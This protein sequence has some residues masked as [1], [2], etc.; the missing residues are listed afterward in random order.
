[1]NSTN[2]RADF[3]RH[4]AARFLGLCFVP[5]ALAA[6]TGG[7]NGGDGASTVGTTSEAVTG[8][9]CGFSVSTNIK[10]VNKKGFRAI[11]KVTRTDGGRLNTTGLSVLVNAGAATLVKVGH[12][13]FQQVENGY[14]LSAVSGDETDD[15]CDGDD[16]TPNDPD[17]LAGRAYRFHLKFEGTYTNLTTTM[18][19]SGG[20]TCDQAAPSV[21]LTTSGELFTSNGTLTLSATASDNVAVSKVVFARDGVE[22]GTVKTAPYTA[23]VPVT[24]AINGRHTFTATA[25][26]LAGNQAAETKRALVAIGNKFFGTAAI[27]AGDYAGLLAHFNQV[28]PGNA[29]KWGSVE[30]TRDVM[31]FTD[32]DTA[33]QFAK[34]NHLPFKLHTLVWG[35]QQPAWIAGL[36]A[37]QQLAELDQWMSALAERYPDADLVDVVNEP[38]HAPPPY[39]AALGGAG[40]TGWDWVVKAFEMARD[41]FP[42]SELLLNDYSILT[43]AQ[44]TQDYLKIVKILNDRGLI[45]GIGEQGHFYERAPEL[46]VLSA[47]LSS[48]VATGLPIYVSE[49]DLNFSDDAQQANRMRDLFSIFWSTPSVLGITHWGYRQQNVWQ[50]NSYL[51]RTD[52]SVRPALTWI[53]CYRAGGTDCPVPPYVPQP[54]TGDVTGITLEAEEYDSAHALLPAGSV[55]AYASDGSWFGYDKVV[56]DGN[57]DTLGVSYAQGGSSPVSLTLHL[58]S[59]DSTPIATVP[60]TP[61]G[62]WSTLQT[63]SIPWAPIAGQHAVFAKF[64]GGGANID[65]LTF[66]A[67]SGTGKNLISDSDLEQGTTAGFFSWG[68]GNIANST[69]RAASGTHS[70]AMTGRSAGA[71]LARS[72]T[73]LVTAGKTYKVSLRASIGGVASAPAY[74]T[75]GIQCGTEATTYGRLGGWDNTKTITDGSWVEFA[76]DLVVPDCALS[77]VQFWLEGPDAGVDMYLD[78]ISVRQV[79]SANIVA[80]GTFESG[81]SGWYTFN[82]G[83]VSQASD[84]AHGGSKSLVVTNRTSNAPAT[85]D[86]TS[87]V[88]AGQSYPFSLWVSLHN[89]DSS[90]GN[91]NVTQAMTCKAA[92][93]TLSTAYNWIA[94]PV[95]VSGTG[96]WT[97]FSGTITVPNCTLTQAQFWVE[98]AVGSDLYVDDVQVIDNAAGGSTNLIGDG[99]FEAG[100]GA[101]GGWGAASIAVTSTSAHGGTQ[102]L[103]GSGMS[104]GALARDIQALVAPGKRYQATAWVSVGNLAASGSVNFQTIQNCNADT[105]DSYPWLA[106]ATVNNSTWV[107]VTGT[108][109]LTACTSINK[110]LLFVGAAAGDLYVDDV[111]LTPLP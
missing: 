96:A 2:Q 64:N 72:L 49:L 26:D 90:S 65:K 74:V 77:N 61:T 24:S 104:N 63:V 6:C 59:V 87:V 103:L 95:A 17:V 29:G 62:G 21:S 110:L 38:L 39:A 68:S 13:T 79:T 105:S 106:G 36:P 28:T 111:T 56:F 42:K 15:D 78:H 25:Y 35:Q 94:N 37:D 11:V 98:G 85:T 23:L 10:K 7:A 80:N 54:R 53:E 108:V 30:A 16:S 101:W 45:D 31:N 69:A 60:L 9:D 70:L 88:K 100:K 92:D 40:A 91:V 75:T 89:A 71:P 27:D 93:G 46:S 32:L 81:T 73:S 97:Q 52:G 86:I 4:G 5:L 8:A 58:D 84:R 109:D 33:Y 102:S 47:N 34:T 50:P 18:M 51:I 99:T 66:T 82:G 3:R 67:P 83:T 55:V 57:W 20:T 41:H 14:L 19:A 48:L 22:I 107:Q 1:M 12:G 43:M 44:S 76:G